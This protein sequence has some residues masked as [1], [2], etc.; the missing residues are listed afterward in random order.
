MPIDERPISVV[1]PFEKV[2]GKNR[3]RPVLVRVLATR[4]VEACLVVGQAPLTAPMRRRYNRGIGTAGVMTGW[5]ARC[6]VVT[7]RWHRAGY[8]RQGVKAAMAN[9]DD[10]L[11][12]GGKFI[13]VG[14]LWFVG[15]ELRH[16]KLADVLK[17]VVRADIGHPVV[18]SDCPLAESFIRWMESKRPGKHGSMSPFSAKSPDHFA[19]MLKVLLSLGETHILIDPNPEL[20]NVPCRRFKIAAVIE[21]I[22]SRHA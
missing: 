3:R 6:R 22:E 14:P 2:S 20:T 16:A 21:A 5:P 1:I 11:G 17:A 7:P 18:F 8:A 15:P 9:D 10:E 12:F 19:E 13:F 4:L